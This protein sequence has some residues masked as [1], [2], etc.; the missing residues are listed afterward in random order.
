MIKLSIETK[1]L[2]DIEK[3]SEK[4]ERFF[5][6]QE[7]SG[8]KITLAGKLAAKD[9]F[10]KNIGIAQPGRFYNKIEVDRMPSGRPF[11]RVLE[12]KLSRKLSGYRSSISISHTKDE[13]V[14]ICILYK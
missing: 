9:A 11:I 7:R 8:S 1:K 4:I 13:A 12:Q 3:V 14:A 5:T 10:L 6:E 2:E